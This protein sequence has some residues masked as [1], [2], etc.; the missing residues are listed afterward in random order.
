MHALAL[1]Q[2]VF[3]H[4]GFRKLG[5]VIALSVACC[6]QANAQGAV[7]EF[8]IHYPSILQTP[9]TCHAVNGST[10]EIT[11]AHNGA[12]ALWITGQNYDALVKVELGGQ[13]TF[14]A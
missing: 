8:T 12:G 10:H 3:G 14:Y 13:M 2:L 5:V 4:S 1:P 6:S 11:Y 9:S 7:E